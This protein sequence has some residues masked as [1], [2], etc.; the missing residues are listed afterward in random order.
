MGGSEEVPVSYHLPR[1]LKPES[2]ASS[3]YGL[4]QWLWRAVGGTPG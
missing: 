1:A 2:L 3:R 4:N